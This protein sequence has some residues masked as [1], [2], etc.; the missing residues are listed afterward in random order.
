LSLFY[1]SS[2]FLISTC[3]I[4]IYGHGWPVGRNLKGR[5]EMLDF[6]A[7]QGKTRIASRRDR[8]PCE[9]FGTAY[10]GAAYFGTTSCGTTSFG[11]TNVGTAQDGT[12]YPE[13]TEK[14]PHVTCD[15]F[16]IC[17]VSDAVF[18]A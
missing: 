13:T 1:A 9:D 12:N 17:A 3:E 10:C 2:E 8:R 4:W 11:T 18:V 6:S 5:A 15:A 16:S 7:G 14:A